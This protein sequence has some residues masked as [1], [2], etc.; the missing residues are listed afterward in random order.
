MFQK[1]R[2]IEFNRFQKSLPGLLRIVMFFI[3]LLIGG[4]KSET[5]G[6]TKKTSVTII[7]DYN[8]LQKSNFRFEMLSTKAYVGKSVRANDKV[9]LS[10]ELDLQNTYRNSLFIS[11]IEVVDYEKDKVIAS[12][13]SSYLKVHLK[14][15]GVNN[16]DE[17]LEMKASAYAIANMWLELET[18]E[19]P[20]NFFH[21]IS[22]QLEDR[23]GDLQET[24]EDLTLVEFP[25]QTDL[26][27]G[28]PFNK[29]KWFY[30]ANAHRDSRSITE[31]KP[32]Y[33]QR[34]ALDWA[35]ITEDNLFEIDSSETIETYVTY[36]QDILAVS[37]AEVVFVK[38][39]IAENNPFSNRLAVRITRETIGGNYVVLDIGNGVYAFYGHLVPGSLK[40]KVGDK[41]KEG[42]IL[43]RLGNSGNSSGPHLHFHLETKS[44]YPLGGEGIPYVFDEFVQLAS[45]SDDE[46]EKVIIPNVALPLNAV[47][48]KRL[49]QIPIGNGVV[50][51]R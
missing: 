29:G 35:A 28:L 43:G 9:I 11:K 19:L 24:K 20:E 5:N 10:Y 37:D 36:K 21:R 4:C 6:I 3:L 51:F 27:I 30:I 32:T 7:E 22:F 39:S 45:Y 2:N 15:P 17:L 12:F 18:D 14:R 34:Y 42:D 33:P 23:Q 48:T 50:E 46:I 8:Y 40:V 26:K 47:E 13:D 38:D 16:I 31:G 1:I 49:N 25:E 44:K 41:V